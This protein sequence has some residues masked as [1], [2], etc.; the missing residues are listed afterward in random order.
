M[1]QFFI[2]HLLKQNI[3]LRFLFISYTSKNHATLRFELTVHVNTQFW[4]VFHKKIYSST[5]VF[6]IDYN[7]KCFL[8]ILLEWF[9]KDHVT[10]KT[11]VMMLKIHRNKWHFTYK[12]NCFFVFKKKITFHSIKIVHF[13][14]V[15]LYNKF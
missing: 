13:K 4:H 15:T 14:L 8:C 10:L 3:S 9:L 5:T 7:H 2:I 11:G 1:W 6:N 12:E